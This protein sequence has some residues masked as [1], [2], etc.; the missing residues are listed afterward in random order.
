MEIFRP[1][2]KPTAA[3]HEWDPRYRVVVQSLVSQLEKLRSD[4]AFEHVGSTAV[5]GCGGKG[6]IDLL[7]LYDGIAVDEVKAWLLGLGLGRQGTEFSRPWRESRPMYLGWYQFVGQEWLFY[8]HVVS[9]S[10]DEVRRFR[11]FRDLL[12]RTPELVASYCS[13]KRSII[14]LGVTDTDDYAVQKRDF[15]R[16]ALGR[17]HELASV[18]DSITT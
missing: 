18:Q 3:Y 16:T 17:Q 9:A 1:A 15:F 12:S 10:S 8:V 4:V 11:A 14:G 5:V 7:A 2:S 6:V 13:L